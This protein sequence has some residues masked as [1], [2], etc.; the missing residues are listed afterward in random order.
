MCFLAELEEIYKL[1][2]DDFGS[3]CKRCGQCCVAPPLTYLEFLYIRENVSD[4]LL[5][6]ALKERS[7]HRKDNAPP[8][9]FLVLNTLSECGIYPFR[10][11]VCRK[12]GRF[13]V[14]NIGEV[15][16]VCLEPK[17]LNLSEKIKSLNEKLQLP[18]NLMGYKKLS[19]WIKRISEFGIRNSD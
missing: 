1:I 16:S 13:D 9:P 10:P 12:V 17:Y 8:C 4:R 14:P 18:P 2:P 11:L 5:K 15:C 6:E 19:K 3:T 7:S